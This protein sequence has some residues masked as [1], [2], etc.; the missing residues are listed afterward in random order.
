MLF[1]TDAPLW[2]NYGHNMS[3]Q[4]PQGFVSLTIHHEGDLSNGR[5]HLA[6]FASRKDAVLCLIGAG[7]VIDGDTARVTH[8]V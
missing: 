5:E 8:P 1:N 3:K 4:S 2:L 7:W 6:R